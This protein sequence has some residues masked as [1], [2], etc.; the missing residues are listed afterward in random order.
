MVSLK[1]S[2]KNTVFRIFRPRPS[3]EGRV[4]KRT[5]YKAEEDDENAEIGVSL[6]A[7]KA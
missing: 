1:H 2:Q 5:R 7:H 6:H 3:Y 4:A